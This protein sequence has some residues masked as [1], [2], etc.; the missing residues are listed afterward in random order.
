MSSLQ[1]LTSLAEVST[2]QSSAWENVILSSY[3]EALAAWLR[4]YEQ[5]YINTGKPVPEDV[6]E[7]MAAAVRAATIYE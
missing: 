7:I 5:L 4:S 6:W 3:L 1:C 2:D